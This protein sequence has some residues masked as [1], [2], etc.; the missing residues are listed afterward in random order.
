MAAMHA[1]I[2]TIVSVYHHWACLYDCQVTFFF[3]SPPDTPYRLKAHL[4]AEILSRH[5]PKQ[6]LQI[7]HVVQVIGGFI[8]NGSLSMSAWL[9]LVFCRWEQEAS[10]P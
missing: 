9:G 3:F 2:D 7:L 4:H 5:K 6:L 10:L 8:V 1:F